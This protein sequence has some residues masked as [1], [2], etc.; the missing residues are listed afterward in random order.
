M[1]RPRR[2]VV[3]AAAFAAL[4]ALLAGCVQ[5]SSTS[6]TT[7]GGALADGG[8]VLRVLAG[9]EVKDMLPILAQA[10]S[11]VGVKVELDYIGTLDGT[12]EVASG[13]AKG[14]Y[15]A[16]WFPNNRYLSLLPGAS[17]A[18]GTSV[19]IMSSPVVFGLRQS[20]AQKLGWDTKPPTWAEL[21]QAASAG[22]FTYGMTNPAASNS[23]FSALVSVATALSGTGTSLTDSDIT[24]VTPQ[25]STFFSGQKLTA[26]SSGFLADKFSADPTSVDGIINYESVLKGLKIKGEPL[27]IITPTDGVVTSDYPLTLL[28]S[29]AAAKKPLFTKLT[30]W[31]RSTKIQKEIASQTHRRPGVP[32]ID[33]GNEF[34]KTVAF[35]TPFPNTLDVANTLI[36]VYLD[37]ARPPAQTLFVLDTS[38]SMDGS[39]LRSLQQALKNLA[40]AD[41]STTGSFAEFANR[42]R[43]TLL[44][45]N[46]KPGSPTTFEVPQDNKDA[47]LSQIRD[48]ADQ[49]VA[50]G[51]TDIYST[52]K[53]AYGIALQQQAERPGTI[54]SIVLMT[55]GE[56]NQG[57]SESDFETYFRSLGSDGKA[58]PTYVVLFGDANVQELTKLATA[59][60]GTTFDALNGD[61]ASAFQAIRGYQ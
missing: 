57:I 47:V 45:F 43:V 11:A 15:D 46:T 30:N 7:S 60:G 8:T 31:L 4:A 16:T 13:G 48:Y 34:P 23:G 26:G 28:T 51:N 14:K 37:A 22:D 58:I 9:S 44:P 12:Q 2:I 20:V 33:T 50:D 27:T 24:T 35:E 5:S 54:V 53:K 18:I 42:E 25:M 40:G 55:D 10:E 41:T 19:K 17:T 59:T 38:G 6:T 3:A 39:R 49:L 36:A 21:A 52:L 1:M 29:A 32:G 56:N 61:L